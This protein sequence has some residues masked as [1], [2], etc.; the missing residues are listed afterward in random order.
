M[1]VNNAD[2]HTKA[3]VLLDPIP[4][5]FRLELPGIVKQTEFELP[6][7]S[8]LTGFVDYSKLVFTLGTF[9]TDLIDLLGNLSQNLI[10]S[11]GNIG[12]NFSMSYELESF[13]SSLDMIAEIERG[14]IAEPNSKNIY[15]TA[16]DEVLGGALGW[17]HGIIMKEDTYQKEDILRGHLYLQGMPRAAN[18]ATH[19]TTNSTNVELD[20]KGYS[21][22]YDWLLMNLMGIQDR[23]VNVF[24]QKIPFDVD[25]KID[26]ELITNLEIGGEMQ[27]KIDISIFD[28]G[29]DFCSDE[30]GGLYIN[31]HTYDP[32][33]SIREVM[34]SELPSKMHLD[35]TLQKRMNLYYDASDEIEFIY[36][37]LSKILTNSWNHVN[38]IL[39][40]LP[41][42]FKVD[43]YS[44]QA[45]DIDDPL[46]LQG[47]P[48][49]IIDTKGTN[50]L[51]IML[52]LQGAA[53]G[54]RGDVE[55]AFSNVRDTTG[56]FEDNWYK[57]E[58]DGLDFIRLKIANLPILDNYKVN[59]LILEA[60]ELKSLTFKVN[61]IFGVF[62]Y[63]DLG[64]N[65]EGKIEIYLDH[66]LTIFNKKMNA[67]VALIDIV[68]ENAGGARIPVASPI[69]VNSVNSDIKKTQR[70]VLIPAILVSLIL[71]WTENM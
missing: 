45:F 42:K 68:Y 7:M 28:S 1:I 70:H 53:I 67:Q 62:P 38:L 66:T 31:M 11:I 15:E 3:K 20:F 56:I 21:P 29:C 61:L 18:I 44:N 49:I 19:F 12:F 30:I 64:S 71:T 46:P 6:D 43:L 5:K 22:T 69:Y 9:G 35:F 2:E 32:I 34:L 50:T 8:N 52:S 17:T 47:M 63:F 26:A 51:D 25:F 24:F 37:K 57:I 65:S 23:D 60:E 48:R 41:K 33:Q 14:G 54:Q 27:G 55:L 40:D 36:S 16:T 4:S 10:D 13:G 39:H 58:S 59:S